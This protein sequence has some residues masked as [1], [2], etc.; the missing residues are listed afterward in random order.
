MKE[1][2]WNEWCSSVTMDPLYVNTGAALE[3]LEMLDWPLIDSSALAQHLLS[4]CV[5][6]KTAHHSRLAHRHLLREALLER[7]N[8]IVVLDRSLRRI[9]PVPD[10]SGLSGVSLREVLS[11]LINL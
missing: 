6:P 8:S 4:I 7:R 11:V 5:D 2:L 10:P 3:K 1:E 9:D